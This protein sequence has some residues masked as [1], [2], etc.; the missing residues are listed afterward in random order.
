MFQI[1]SFR[2]VPTVG[3]VRECGGTTNSANPDR[4]DSR[5]SLPLSLPS[6]SS[7]KRCEV[8]PLYQLVLPENQ[9]AALCPCPPLLSPF[10]R[11]IYI[12]QCSLSLRG[13]P[14]LHW[15]LRKRTSSPTYRQASLSSSPPISSRSFMFSSFLPS[16]ALGDLQPQRGF[17]SGLSSRIRSSSVVIS[18]KF[19]YNFLWVTVTATEPL[20]CA[21]SNTNK[22][23]TFGAFPSLSFSC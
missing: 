23:T 5:L 4:P 15:E 9:P 18:I 19:E 10:Q 13:A 17:P 3:S 1:R 11:L 2:F 20:K 16:F 12:K 21:T 22:Q 7:W 8:S 14:G 6:F